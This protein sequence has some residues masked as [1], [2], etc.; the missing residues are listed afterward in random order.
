MSIFLPPIYVFLQTN[1]NL[2]E[3]NFTTNS[4]VRSVA[5]ESRL[6]DL[7]EV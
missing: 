7:Q 4:G 3:K 5:S 6:A 2:E 1:K